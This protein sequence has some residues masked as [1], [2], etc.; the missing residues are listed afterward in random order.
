MGER[1]R[2]DK[3]RPRIISAATAS[4][5][6]FDRDGRRML[7]PPALYL[8]FLAATPKTCTGANLESSP[9]EKL[10]LVT[11]VAVRVHEAKAGAHPTPAGRPDWQEDICT[12]LFARPAL[13]G[14]CRKV[15]VEVV[16]DGHRLTQHL[17]P[18]TL[19]HGK[20]SACPKSETP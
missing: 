13:R 16:P 20:L 18:A 6:S 2:P 4:A 17:L 14:L 10:S 12:Q 5:P 15:H 3:V 11:G 8:T 19:A 7:P 9:L 1:L